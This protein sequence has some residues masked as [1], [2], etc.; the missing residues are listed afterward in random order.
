MLDRPVIRAVATNAPAAEIPAPK[1]KR[2]RPRRSEVWPHLP[3]PNGDHLVPRKQ[4][5]A[6]LGIC[7][8]PLVRL[9]EPTTIFGGVAYVPDCGTRQ[10]IAHAVSKPKRRRVRRSP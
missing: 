3:L 1:A 5:A 9:R 7:E 6:L 2:G 8:G 10:V 4:Q